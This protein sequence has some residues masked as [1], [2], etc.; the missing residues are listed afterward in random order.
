MNPVKNSDRTRERRSAESSAPIRFAGATLGK[1]RHI[2]AFFRSP[3]EEYQVL[4][5]F[6]KEGLES[7]EKAF[8]VVD[9]ALCEDHLQRLESFGIDVAAAKQ[10]SQFELFDWE[11]RYFFE[12][13]FD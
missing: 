12:G 9:R 10:G 1:Q 6:I 3:D 11:E 5:P 13:R 4:L 2:C 7:G 8:H